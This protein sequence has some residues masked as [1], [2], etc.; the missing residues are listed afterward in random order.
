V[1]DAVDQGAH[2]E[3]EGKNDQA[4]R[5]MHPII[6]TNIPVASRL[7]QEEIFGP[8]LPI[9]SYTKIEE[10]LGIIHSKPKPL[11]LYVFATQRSLRDRI[12][13]ET[14]AGTVCINDCG[15]QFLHHDLPFGGINNSGMGK[16]HGHFG[17]ITFSNE[18]PVLKQKNGMTAVQAFY[19]PFTRRTRQIMDWFLKLF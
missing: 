16:S 3:W 7:M 1:K 2:I 4:A 18:K 15:I 17:F 13:R 8:V 10:A 19:P 11:A 9:I 6:L 12:I 14:S 5:F